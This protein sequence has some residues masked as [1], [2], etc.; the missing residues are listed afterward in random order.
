VT[1]SR[2]TFRHARWQGRRSCIR[3]GHR[4][5][6]KLAEGR[7]R[8][9]KCRH[10]FGEFTGTYLGTLRALNPAQ[11]M[12]VL[13]LFALEV[14]AHRI[15]KEVGIAWPTALHAAR[16][17]RQA[18]YDAA[19]EELRRLH[20]KI[21]L[22]ETMFGGRR[23]GKRGWGAEGKVIVFGML[24]RNGHV[25]T[26]PLP[27]RR[28]KH[29]LPLIRKH[30]RKGSW[31][32]T[33]DWQGYGALVLQG[34]HRRVRHKAEQY[35]KGPVHINGMEGFWSYAKERFR[36]YHGVSPAYFPLYLKEVEFRF[37]HRHEDLLPLLAR[38]IVKPVPDVE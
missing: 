32:F 19:M 15:A 28:R 38:T 34:K 18:L 5:P 6:W 2:V 27:A 10:T 31:F 3:C 7:F 12:H 17:I 21:E 4:G 24:E 1:K 13:Y 16:V 9:R 22:D 33:D 29:I 14:P 8:C 26:F 37:N 20:G 23:H 36:K 30:A 25:L 11:W 35:A